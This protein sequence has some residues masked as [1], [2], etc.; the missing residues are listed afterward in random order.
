MNYISTIIRGFNVS[1]T[2]TQ[3]RDLLNS[4]NP[5]IEL[6]EVL[7]TEKYGDSPYDLPKIIEAERK[8]IINKAHIVEFCFS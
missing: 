6:T 3:L 1:E 8:V 4:E 5:F 7:R 2:E